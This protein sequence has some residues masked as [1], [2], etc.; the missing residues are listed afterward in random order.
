MT[1]PA[2][3]PPP[4]RRRPLLAAWLP[5]EHPGRPADSWTVWCTRP[6][7]RCHATAVA[8]THPDGDGHR[9][10]RGPIAERIIA[11]TAPT[12]PRRRNP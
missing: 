2:R 6:C 3:I 8:A 1:A 7:R 4:P 12:R 11:R 9:L 5:C 10:L